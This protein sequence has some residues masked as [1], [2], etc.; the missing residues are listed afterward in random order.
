MI[1]VSTWK[2]ATCVG[3]TAFREG[4][5]EVQAP[6]PQTKAFDPPPSYPGYLSQPGS[7]G[8]NDASMDALVKAITDEVI[9]ALKA[10]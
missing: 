1:L 6:A 10:S 7:S 4:Y 8:G 2:T 3:N 9:A 5:S